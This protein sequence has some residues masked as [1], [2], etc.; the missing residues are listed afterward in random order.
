MVRDTHLPAVIVVYSGWQ[1]LRF[2]ARAFSLTSFETQSSSCDFI[3]ASRRLICL[4]DLNN[5]KRFSFVRECDGFL[6]CFVM[7]EQARYLFFF[8]K[9]FAGC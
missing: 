1:D 4:L 8:C 5:L 3:R 6:Q 7:L 9:F 2:N